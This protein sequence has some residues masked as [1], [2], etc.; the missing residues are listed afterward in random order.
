MSDRV[1]VSV[2][3]GVADVRLNR[4]E[5]RNALD[6]AMFIALAEA[7]ERMKTE[8]GLRCVV[9]SGEGAS[10]CAG[11]DFGS[12]QQMSDGDRAERRPGRGRAAGR[13]PG[14]DGRRAHHPPRPAGGLGVAGGPGPGHRRG[15]RPRARRR[16]PDR[17]RRRHPHRA[18]GRP[19]VGPGG[20]LG[21][22]AGHDRD[23]DPQPS[24]APRRGQGADLHRQ[25]G[26]GV[27]GPRAGPGHPAL[28]DAEGGRAGHGG[29]DRRR[30]APRPSAARR[31]CSTACSAPVRPSSSRRSAGSSAA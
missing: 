6:G 1:T 2:D 25:D 4:P 16:D 10:F 26:V 23:A 30:G 13:Q 19:A 27:R 12:F 14:V 3:A 15:A 22:G 21:A 31:P 9:L 17:A 11:L 29:R 8:P 24:R 20:P 7:G 28:R 18:P 5:K